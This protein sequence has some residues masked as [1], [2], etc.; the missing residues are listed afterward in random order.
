[1]RWSP[2]LKMLAIIGMTTMQRGL[3]IGSRIQSKNTQKMTLHSGKE[4]IQRPRKGMS[5]C[6]KENNPITSRHNTGSPRYQTSQNAQLGNKKPAYPCSSDFIFLRVKYTECRLASA[7]VVSSS[8]VSSSPWIWRAM[9]C[10]MNH[11]LWDIKMTFESAS[12]FDLSLIS[13]FA[14]RNHL[15]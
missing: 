4:P 2:V 8:A 3:R 5:K 7:A 14:T 9:H 11:V 12:P 15:P 10:V 13:S 6:A 1:M